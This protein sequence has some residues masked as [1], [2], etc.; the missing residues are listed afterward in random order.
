MSAPA[1]AQMLSTILY[2][3]RFFP[4]YVWNILGGLDENGIHPHPD[5]IN[6]S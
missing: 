6:F 3:K 4:Y 1:L 5:S 2:S